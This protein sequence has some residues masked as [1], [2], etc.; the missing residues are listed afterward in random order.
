MESGTAR[1]TWKYPSGELAGYGV[2]LGNH[3]A[4]VSV[5]PGGQ[6]GIAIYLA[7]PESGTATGKWTMEKD[8][9]KVGEETYRFVTAE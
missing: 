5:K 9:G 1:L 3:L 6:H 8:L 7:D 2:A 4:A